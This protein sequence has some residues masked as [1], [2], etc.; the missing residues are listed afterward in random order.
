MI[1]I[2][3]ALHTEIAWR[4]KPLHPDC[5]IVPVPNGAWLPAR[6]K[7]E[8]AL[9]ARIVSRLKSE[10]QLLPGAADLCVLWDD[11]SG[12]IELKRPATRTLLERL[13]A[14][15][16]SDAQL[17]FAQ[18]CAEH[19]VR[20]CYATSWEEVRAALVDWGRMR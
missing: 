17:E 9:V 19:G 1:Q 6:T 10:G 18:R 15:R 2:E 4:L 13:P 14:G 3:R 12:T 16:P 20:H 8:R 5:I 7:E 11:G